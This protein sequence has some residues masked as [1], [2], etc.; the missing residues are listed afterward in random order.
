MWDRKFPIPWISHFSVIFGILPIHMVH[1][2][3]INTFWCFSSL[4]NDS[5]L[6]L[7]GLDQFSEKWCSLSATVWPIPLKPL[8]VVL[9]RF[10]HV[11]NHFALISKQMCHKSKW[12]RSPDFV[13][14][15][16]RFKDGEKKKTTN[17]FDFEAWD[18]GAA[19]LGKLCKKGDIVDVVTSARNNSWTDKEGNK[20]FAILLKDIF[21]EN[22]LHDYK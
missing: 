18:S 12:N 14:C 10:W 6:F 1:W 5:L 16:Q 3:I 17:Y 2:G 7:S 19:T 8:R 15:L 20:K 21:I 9:S 13:F 4:Y 11:F 22:N